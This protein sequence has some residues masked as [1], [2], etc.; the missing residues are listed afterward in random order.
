VP[1][2]TRTYVAALVPDREQVR[3]GWVV[4]VVM[5]AL[6]GSWSLMPQSAAGM[7]GTLQCC[8]CVPEAVAGDQGSG[9]D[10]AGRRAEAQV[11][12]QPA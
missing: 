11:I 4:P 10:G 5:T 3:S 9:R 1:R 7:A 12:T 2:L 8:G 6:L